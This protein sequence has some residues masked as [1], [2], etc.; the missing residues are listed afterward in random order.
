MG[1]STCFGLASELRKTE[2]MKDEF[3][4]SNMLQTEQLAGSSF[5]RNALHHTKPILHSLGVGEGRYRDAENVGS[6][7][8][9]AGKISTYISE[10]L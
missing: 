8:T 5:S 6:T 9:I 4:H 1:K 3:Y 7:W 10:L 2:I